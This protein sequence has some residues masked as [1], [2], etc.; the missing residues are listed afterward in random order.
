MALDLLEQ[1]GD[2]GPALLGPDEPPAFEVINRD[3]KAA[4]LLTC[5]HASCTVPRA[6]G[7]LALDEA[8][9]RRHIGWDIGAAAVTRT[10]AD[11]L[12]APAVLAGY[13]RL[14]IDANRSLDD[15]TSIPEISDGVIIQANRGLAE[16][17]RQR[18]VD[19][20]FRPYHDA[21]GA[22]IAAL[23]RQG[24]APVIIAVHSFTPV[25]KGHARPWHFGVLWNDDARVPV[26]LM[27]RLGA[28][29]GICVGDN[30]PYSAR[31]GFGYTMECHGGANG[32]AHALVELRQD[33]VD[34]VHGAEAW[35]ARLARALQHVLAQ[36][37]LYCEK[38]P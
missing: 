10:L 34:T 36:V 16:A 3:G 7:G 28:E 14:V 2:G 26:P 30:K 23:R 18:R 5:D 9:L 1:Q 33:L 35:S 38:Q 25:M 21:I 6:L 31:E 8:V 29:P 15:P 17:D 32:L 13:S 37:E 20:V 24:P 12:D 4:V 22:T 19:A 11:A 27:E